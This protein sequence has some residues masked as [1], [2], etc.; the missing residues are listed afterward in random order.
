M[1][2]R[3]Y[4]C[5]FYNYIS[6]CWLQFKLIE[7]NNFQPPPVSPK[8]THILGRIVWQLLKD[9]EWAHGLET[10]LSLRLPACMWNGRQ[11][12]R[13][14]WSSLHLGK[15]KLPVT[16]QRASFSHGKSGYA[17]WYLNLLLQLLRG[18]SSGV[19]LYAT[20]DMGVWAKTLG[21]VM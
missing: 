5:V 2:V 15:A 12:G 1:Y 16:V 6:R 8:P 14:A 9:Q 19:G 21:C 3:V 20:I 4:V 17:S 10:E 7:N 11:E 18:G 13:G